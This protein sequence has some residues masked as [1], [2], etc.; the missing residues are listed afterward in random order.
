LS[1]WLRVA[2]GQAES[3]D[4]VAV[5]GASGCGKTSFLS[6]LAMRNQRFRGNVYLNCQPVDKWYLSLL[7]E[8][9]MS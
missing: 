3:R 6:C 2:V 4:F 1:A 7:G 9:A 8:W 5:M